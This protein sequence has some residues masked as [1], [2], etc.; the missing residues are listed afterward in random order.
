MKLQISEKMADG[1]AVKSVVLKAMVWENIRF[2]I[3]P[4]YYL[5]TLL[6]F[7]ELTTR[8]VCENN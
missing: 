4:S 2:W 6:F 7:Y 1:V 5:K 8:K 3:L